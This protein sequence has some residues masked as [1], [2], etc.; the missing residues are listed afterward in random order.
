MNYRYLLI[1]LFFSNFSFSQNITSNAIAPTILDP[2]LL[3]APNSFIF[4]NSLP[5]NDGLYIPV[6]KAYDMWENGNYMGDVNQVFAGVQS[7]SVFWEDVSGI[8]KSVVIVPGATPKDAKIKV[9]IDKAKGKGNAVIAF[10]IG[11]NGN[12]NDD[13]YWSWHV[14]VT[15]TPTVAETNTTGLDYKV[16]NTTSFIPKIM[17]RN[18]G[19]T[20][21]DFVG[22]GW[23]K[24]NGLY[25]QWGRKDPFPS[26]TT[27]DG[28]YQE[29]YTQ[30]FGIVDN[31]FYPGVKIPKAIRPS[32]AIFDNIR[33][34]VL[35]PLTL[36]ERSNIQ[37]GS[38]DAWFSSSIFENANTKYYD[39]WG[40]NNKGNVTQILP[41]QLGFSG[42]QIKSPFD[43]C[44]CNFRVPSYK[45]ANSTQSKFSV[46]GRNSTN[47]DD[48]TDALLNPDGSSTANDLFPDIRIFPALGVDFTNVN[49]RD[50]GKMPLSG[51]IIANNGSNSFTSNN[52]LDVAS[53]INTWSATLGLNGVRYLGLINDFARLNVDPN[54]G[55]YRIDHTNNS[56]INTFGLT[57][58]CIE[59]PNKNSLPNYETE[60]FSNNQLNYKTGL[61]NPNSYIIE[62]AQ[63]NLA[64]P[65]S[66]AFAIFN[67]YLSDHQLPSGPFQ[68]K[69]V[70]T[71]NQNLVKK[72]SVVGT[73]ENATINV[74]FGNNNPKGNAVVS[75]IDGLGTTIW[76]WHLWAP[77]TA[78]IALANY[79]TEDILTSA[80]N[81]V[82]PTKSGLPPLSTV[83]MDRNLG[84]LQSF[85]SISTTPN[86]AEI[87]Q[88]RN[89]GGM[90]Y[91][92]GRKDPL[93]AFFNPVI[94]AGATSGV[95]DDSYVVFLESG[96]DANGN[97][98][99]ATSLSYS[100]HKSASY[101]IPYNTYTNGL[102]A[103]V[104]PTD[105][106]Y[107]QIRKVLKYSVANPL[108]LLYNTN[109][110]TVS[111]N[112]QNNIDW[113]S[114]K[115]NSFQERWGHGE[116]KS[117]FDPCPQGW[118]IPDVSFAYLTGNTNELID[119]G[120]YG[121]SPWYFGNIFRE[122]KTLQG[123]SV[124][125]Y[126]LNQ[127]TEY[128]IGGTNTLKYNGFQ[129]LR[130]SENKRYGWVFNTFDYNI[131]NFPATGYRA[132]GNN[133]N[134]DLI[135]YNT[136]VW[137]AS[138]G[139][140]NYGR[141]IALEIST[142]SAAAN[143][144]LKTGTGIIPQG[145]I[146]C[147]CAK[148]QYD[149][150]GEEIGRYDPDA[151]PQ[152]GTLGIATIKNSI[153]S[154]EEDI[155]L[156]PNP[157]KNILKIAS[158]SGIKNFDF[159]IF[160]Q[161]GRFIKSGKLIDSVLDVSFLPKG[162]YHFIINNDDVSIKIIKE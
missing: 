25:Y 73:D 63:V 137:S 147:R 93:P 108:H 83:F 152:G 80:N 143:S 24:S 159:K 120:Q 103:N 39:L 16:D 45:S 35:N 161:T 33:F 49:G 21:D 52:F 113:I 87:Q 145:A 18:L 70:W 77:Q 55:L 22:N 72:V 23:A 65:I 86:A 1:L 4:D 140:Q 124:L 118:R 43:P 53:E 41:G 38:L 142:G 95:G 112:L 96:K 9:E 157:T 17:D 162:V 125:R 71:T 107:I 50:M 58:R 62:D 106:K 97:S 79:K 32:A 68:T 109:F 31:A 66:K 30:R 7:T 130:N 36:I 100:T 10:H 46:W 144:N 102:N 134:M 132:L 160:D 149:A 136:A 15:D 127:T 139:D 153:E 148:I 82:N 104:L 85:P 141:A 28:L 19:A 75:L 88:I 129:I 115:S 13:V 121:N 122:N 14:W 11:T 78:P 59:D 27:K 155:T 99:Y 89:S 5:Q 76:S 44:P 101:S 74:E 37:Q 26:L 123:V 48:L 116:K 67:Q 34:S 158:K 146:P 135:G 131:G 110:T 133:P 128:N 8:I 54:F 57:V 29:L 69:V 105:P 126:G 42:Y 2:T 6:K 47:N 151:M 154:P 114:N 51:R 61:Y 90:F 12:A 94:P 40:D 64:I 84:A 119:D 81:L 117:P 60:Y 56:A 156:F 138:L 3:A 20:S 111:G 98:L 150:D 91:Q 92:W